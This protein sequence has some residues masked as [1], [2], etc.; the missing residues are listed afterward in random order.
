MKILFVFKNFSKD[1]G[2]EKVSV[3][4]ARE[5][6][7]KGHE[8][9][10][11]VMNGD[12][13]F[14]DSIER[15][16][17][18]SVSSVSI[19]KKIANLKKYVDYNKVDTIIAAKEQAN[20][21]SILSAFSSVRRILV[22]RHVSFD[23]PGQSLSPFIIK[24]MYAFYSLFA[25]VRIV[26]VSRGIQQELNRFPL[27]KSGVA[28]YCPNAV[29]D[30]ALFDSSFKL[31]GVEHLLPQR[32]ILSVG[33][34]VEQKGFDLLLRAYAISCKRMPEIPP[35][36]VLG[37]GELKDTLISQAKELGIDDKVIFAGFVSNPFPVFKN[38]SLFVLSSRSEGMPTVLI[39]ALALDVKVVAHDCK[40]GPSELLDNGKHGLLVRVGDVAG[41]ANA[42]VNS[43]TD[44]SINQ[45]KFKIIEQYSVKTA[46][47]VYEKYIME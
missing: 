19:I 17:E 39:E 9:A 4:L 16:G 24:M 32:Y 15:V 42:I 6:K 30:Q 40:T 13:L 35:L 11:Y 8:V 41:L 2:V 10:F 14:D 36:V 38:A 28:K 45:D 7:A 26:C 47:N 23:A 43:L 31:S 20:M 33:R 34:L 3:K 27:M 21:I 44:V 25:N 18:L 46:A 12:S 1:G 5:L 37:Q 29:V 22:C